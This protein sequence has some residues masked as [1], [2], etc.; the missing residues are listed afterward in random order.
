MHPRQT[1]PVIPSD[2]IKTARA[3]IGRNNFYLLV[4]DNWETLMATVSYIDTNNGETSQNWMVPTLDIA[5]LLQYKE[6]L[7][8]RQ[9]EEASRLRVDWKYAL[10]LT[11]YYP[12]LSRLLL[13]QNRQRIYL[14]PTRQGVFQS[15][16]D[17]FIEQGLFP[18]R[19]ETPL[20]A[21]TLMDEVCTHSRLEE[22]MLTLRRALEVLATNHPKWLRDIILPHW[23]TRYHLFM[24]APTSL[25]PALNRGSRQK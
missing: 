5:T 15:I 13:C 8:D 12:G 7:S 20:A 14:N 11:M 4:G 19:Q 3:M 22:I 9:A 16:L 10:H 25:I 2:T 23:Y 21:T 6:K 18:E 24:A 17:R 1:L